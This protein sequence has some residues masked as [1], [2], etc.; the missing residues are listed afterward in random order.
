MGY[1]TSEECCFV[2]PEDDAHT[3][4]S[5]NSSRGECASWPGR[6]TTSSGGNLVMREQDPALATWQ[7]SLTGASRLFRPALRQI[8]F[9]PDGFRILK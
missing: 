5:G 3:L 2:L 7:P 8:G 4:W 1:S 9:L 6:S